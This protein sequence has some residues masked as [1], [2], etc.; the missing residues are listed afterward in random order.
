M[1]WAICMS[2]E[3]VYWNE[4]EDG[5]CELARIRITVD[6][7]CSDIEKEHREIANANCGE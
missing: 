6:G 3:C 5:K 1:P 2:K 4:L 7:E